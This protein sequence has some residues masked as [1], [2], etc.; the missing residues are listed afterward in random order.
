MGGDGDPKDHND[1]GDQSRHR[2]GKYL[3]DA[4]GFSF[5][6]THI[7]KALTQILDADLVT[8]LELGD[9]IGLDNPLLFTDKEILKLMTEDM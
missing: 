1:N 9:D 2:N 6:L 5:T 8:G 4:T 3:Y 7:I